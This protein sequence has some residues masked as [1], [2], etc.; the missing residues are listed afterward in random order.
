MSE[1]RATRLF[2]PAAPR[3]V[4][5]ILQW[6]TFGVVLRV[7]LASAY[8]IGGIDKAMDFP[9][10]VAEQAHFGLQPAALWAVLAIA[11]ELIGAVLLIVDRWTWLAAG[12][13]GVLTLVAMAVANNFWDM[14]GQARFMAKN[15]FFEHLGLICGLACVARLSVLERKVLA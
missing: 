11:V 12:A 10:A 3:W 13:L 6:P 1:F 8:L 4:E 15:A 7:G 5:T 9:G 14:S 2:S